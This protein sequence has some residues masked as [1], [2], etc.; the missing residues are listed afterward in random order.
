MEFRAW[1]ST[2]EGRDESSS[3]EKKSTGN[4]AVDIVS[5]QAFCCG[6]ARVFKFFL[7][8]EK[9]TKFVV[10][11]A[12]SRL[13]HL[14]RPIQFYVLLLVD[15]SIVASKQSSSPPTFPCFGR[16]T[17]KEDVLKQLLEE[18][19]SSADETAPIGHGI[20]ADDLDINKQVIELV[21]NA[22]LMVLTQ[23]RS[24][25]GSLPLRMSPLF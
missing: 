10:N 2:F 11:F 14:A 3:A 8:R 20:S 1:K 4:A 19:L 21:V 15:Q 22:G 16:P 7:W 17:M 6:V 9:N 23:H 24:V 13:K 12:W 5:I 25:T 18:L